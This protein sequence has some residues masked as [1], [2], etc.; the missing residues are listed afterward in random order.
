MMPPM[1]TYS[2]INGLANN[3]HL[4]HYGSRA[5]GGAGIV[6]IEATAIEKIG[7]ISIGD[8]ELFNNKH[9]NALSKIA[10]FIEEYGSIPGI[11]ISHS[12]RKGRTYILWRGSGKMDKGDDGWY[13]IA[14]LP[15][16]F[17][18]T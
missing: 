11:E 9:K 1:C 13:T 14:P 16:P 18:E 10:K 5:I 7:R 4:V 15:L 6:M 12:G 2:T 3:F 17:V 8:L